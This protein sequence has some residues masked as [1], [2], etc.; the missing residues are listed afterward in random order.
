VLL[1]SSPIL[2]CDRQTTQR[3]RKEG[4]EGKSSL[5]DK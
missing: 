5:S 4:G 1:L 2:G 3:R